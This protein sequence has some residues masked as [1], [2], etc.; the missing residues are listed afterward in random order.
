M[1]CSQGAK[2][3]IDLGADPRGVSTFGSV[4]RMVAQ[5]DGDAEPKV[6]PGECAVKM[7]VD[8]LAEVLGRAADQGRARREPNY[9][10]TGGRMDAEFVL[11][12]DSI[13]STTARGGSFYRLEGISQMN[14]RRG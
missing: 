1:E 9:F 8:R 11:E 13:E 7:V 6:R 2:P 3:A 14:T 4:I 5:H 12:G 10:A